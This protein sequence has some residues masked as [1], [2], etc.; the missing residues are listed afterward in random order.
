MFVR[1]P[2]ATRSSVVMAVPKG[3]GFHI[4]GDYRGVNQLIEQSV[5]LMS[6]REGLELMVE[7]T[8]A[9]CMLDMVQRY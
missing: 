3:S 7:G 8:A 1:N 2:Q 5:M 6:H 9:C 4:V